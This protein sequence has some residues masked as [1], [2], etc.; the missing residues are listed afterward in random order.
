MVRR[1][2]KKGQPIFIL[3]IF[4]TLIISV[5]AQP[6]LAVLIETETVINPDRVKDTRVLLNQLM[7]REDVRT[8]LLSYWINPVEVDARVAAMTDAEI[9]TVA[10]TM[11]DMPAGG[12]DGWTA[13]ALICLGLVILASFL[14]ISLT[15]GVVYAGIK[16]SEQN[17]QKMQEYSKSTPYPAPPRVGHVPSVNPDEPWTGAWKIIDS[18]D[19]SVYVLKQ[20][21]NSVISTS[22]SD[23]RVEAKVYG[24]MIVGARYSAGTNI[25]HGFKAII[26]DDFLSFKGDINSQTFFTCQKIESKSAAVNV[27]PSGSSGPWAGKWKVQGASAA[28]GLWVLKQ[29]GEAVTSTDESYYRVRGKAAGDKFEGDVMR[30]GAN[31]RDIKF[32]FVLSSDG[33]SFDGITEETTGTN[34]ISGIKVE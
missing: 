9:A 15:S 4:L 34:R 29:E 1:L 31:R 11:K 20:T 28:S 16:V 24:A 18:Q 3:M 17:E 30:L 14:I 2:R 32:N 21:G 5:P 23:Y 6:A 22:E 8:A 12:L 19:S 13:L 25:S 7:A 10:N 27:K 33:K 26:A